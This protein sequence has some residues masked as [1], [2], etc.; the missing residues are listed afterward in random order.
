MS[1]LYDQLMLSIREAAEY[2]ESNNSKPD[3]RARSFVARL[4][5]V[6]A[7]HETFGSEADEPVLSSKV[8]GL[9]DEDPKK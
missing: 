1:N 8:F 6:I 5:G 3:W 2:A 4:A 9:L 7:A